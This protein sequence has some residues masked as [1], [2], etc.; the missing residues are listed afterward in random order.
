VPLENDLNIAIKG[1]LKISRLMNSLISILKFTNQQT[2]VL[3]LVNQYPQ[4]FDD[5]IPFIP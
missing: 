1:A 5:A 2:D 4:E 3:E